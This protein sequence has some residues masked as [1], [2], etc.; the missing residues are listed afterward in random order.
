MTLDVSERRWWKEAAVY[1]IYPSSFADHADGG[2]GTLRGIL[3]KVDYLKDLGIDVLWL[4]PIYTSPMADMGY[5]ISDYQ[6]IDP[7]YGTLEDW[8]ALRDAVHARGM[9]LVM[10]LVVNH[11]S[12]EHAWFRESRSSKTSPKRDWY[13]WHSGKV[14][15]A[16]ERVPPNNW[17][18]TFGVGST[19]EWDE[20]SGEYYLHTFLKEQPDL[21]WENPAVRDAVFEMMR[22]WLDRGADGFRMD[23]I[24]FISK[25][26]GFPDAPITDPKEIYQP[27]GNLSINRPR[28]HDHLKEMYEKVLKD[29][30]CFCVGEC[31]G[32]EGPDSFA[33]Y[34]EPSRNELQMV[35]T[36]HHQCFDRGNG[37]FGRGWNADWKLSDLK[38]EWNRWHTELPKR[39]GWFANYLENH[40]QPRMITR[41]ACESPENRARSGKLLA[42]LQCSLTGTIYVYQGQELGPVNVPHAWGEEE[43]KDVESIQLIQGERAY[44]ERVGITGSEADEYMAGV[45]R[46]LR[47]TARD[48]GRTPVQWDDSKHAG[49]TAGEP[50]MRIHEDYPEWNA[51]AQTK[52]ADSVRSFWKKMLALRTEYPSLVYGKFTPL[53]EES[54]D[55]YCYTREW[56]ETGEKLLVLLNFKRDDG[57]GGPITIDTAKLGV[58]TTGARLIASNDNAKEGSGINGPVTLEPWCGRIYLLKE[59]KNLP[60]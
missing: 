29:Y 21:N 33:L 3:S 37:G 59:G 57:T 22:W 35:F 11:S 1:Q 2:N 36:F 53:D 49:F 32:S 45:L 55:N 5:D 46:D 42:L 54:N 41:M 25:A 10:D 31:P 56:P 44:L 30:D 24:N 6:A 13:I 47:Q 51:A 18:S 19:W 23:V 16:G 52:D 39:G 9:K 48:N 20:G 60:N 40:D 15:E 12:N 58:D 43:Y 34:S 7:R 8:D 14:N 27:F 4:S 28:V 50:W 17:R 38:K 26:E